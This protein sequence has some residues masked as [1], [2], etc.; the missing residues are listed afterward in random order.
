MGAYSLPTSVQTVSSCVQLDSRRRF[1][2][3]LA[4]I[5]SAANLERFVMTKR[6]TTPKEPKI[7]KLGKVSKETKGA[8]GPRWDFAFQRGDIP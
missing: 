7:T 6:D 8:S 3:V 1:R 5:V 4:P 2:I